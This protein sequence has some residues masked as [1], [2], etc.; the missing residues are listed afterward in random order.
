MA[1]VVT[2]TLSVDAAPRSTP[3][4]VSPEAAASD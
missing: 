2:T 3:I 4:P 1:P